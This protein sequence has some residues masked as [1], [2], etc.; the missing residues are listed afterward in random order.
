MSNKKRTLYL[1]LAFALIFNSLF[2][3]A[4]NLQDLNRKKKN[5]NQQMNEK[6][7]KKFKNYKLK[8]KMWQQK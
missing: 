1:I 4:D 2:V 8:L 5:T 3:F 7:K 6:K